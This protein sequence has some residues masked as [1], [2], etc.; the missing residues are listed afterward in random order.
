MTSLTV[1][2][3]STFAADVYSDNETTRVSIPEN[4]EDVTGEV[5]DLLGGERPWERNGFTGAIYRKGTGE[6]TE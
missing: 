3:Y 6:D 2:E 1:F 4:W 5:A